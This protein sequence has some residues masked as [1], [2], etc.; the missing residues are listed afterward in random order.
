MSNVPTELVERAAT[1]LLAAHYQG[2]MSAPT[3]AEIVLDA[4][5]PHEH[6]LELRETGW[7]L[8]HPVACRPDMLGCVYQRRLSAW[9]STVNGPPE[10]PG[11]YRVSPDL[12]LT[13]LD[14]EASA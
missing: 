8:A 2:E 7:T 5:L 6:I 9:L 12:D 4:A 14:E 11:R 13:P 3:V 1:A 10:P